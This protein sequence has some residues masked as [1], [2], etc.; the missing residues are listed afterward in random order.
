MPRAAAACKVCPIR[1][2]CY[3]DN[4]IGSSS[5]ADS[6]GGAGE[7]KATDT[8]T[9]APLVRK[10][11]WDPLYTPDMCLE[12]ARVCLIALK[13]EYEDVW[14]AIGQLSHIMSASA[15][16]ARSAL[17]LTR[18]M[19]K[20]SRLQR[21]NM[22][23]LS[24]LKRKLA[25]EIRV[26]TCRV[27]NA[28][29]AEEK[30]KEEEREEEKHRRSV[31]DGEVVGVEEGGPLR[32]EL[33]EMCGSAAVKSV[34]SAYDGSS[35][36]LEREMLC[37]GGTASKRQYH[38]Y[39]Q[40]TADSEGRQSVAKSAATRP[41]KVSFAPGTFDELDPALDVGEGNLRFSRLGRTYRPGVYAGKAYYDTSGWHEY[42]EDQ[43]QEDQRD[44]KSNVEGS[45][46]QPSRRHGWTA[47]P[48][49]YITPIVILTNEMGES[50]TLVRATLP[51]EESLPFVIAV[52]PEIKILRL[53][54]SPLIQRNVDRF[55]NRGKPTFRWE[56]DFQYTTF[57]DDLGMLR[58]LFWLRGELWIKTSYIK[59]RGKKTVTM[60]IY[61]EPWHDSVG[62]AKRRR[63]LGMILR[64]MG[65]WKAK[66]AGSIERK[67]R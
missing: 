63:T 6:I 52:D 49:T 50:R 45:K 39:L 22:A 32:M 38:T 58:K 59:R 35:P 62:F 8:T 17:R 18:E 26:V 20:K 19:H 33:E 27:M 54:T 34:R 11:N 41:K 36:A 60:D 31:F 25:M 7:I 42:P 30:R 65:R 24:V 23:D 46:Y 14:R 10:T 9:S 21:K 16:D 56:M 51:E 57:Y 12:C 40:D 3:G 13:W 61:S 67:H 66:R 15:L 37:P 64:W 29:M 1:H 2:K 28:D 47:N 55:I 48:S 5:K 44:R 53:V 43:N 4:D